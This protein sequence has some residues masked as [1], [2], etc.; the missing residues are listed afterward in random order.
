MKKLLTII[1]ALTTAFLMT[2]AV[3]A[4][5]NGVSEVEVSLDADSVSVNFDGGIEALTLENG[6]V[7]APTDSN[8]PLFA[9]KLPENV[10]IGDTVVVH[11]KG[12]ADDDF[13]VWLLANTTTDEKGNEATFSNQWQ[14]SQNGF[15]APGEFEKYI[16]L[17][18]EDYDAQGGTEADR[19]AFKGPSYGVNLSNLKLTYVGIIKGSIADVEGTAAEEA[20]P[21]ADA[22]KAA[23][24]AANAANGD[25]AALNAA[26]SDAEA[27]VASL[28]E[29]ATLGFPSVND[30][31][32]EAQDVVKTINGIIN[33][34]AESEAVESIS[35][36]VAAVSDALA[37]AQSAGD[38]IDAIK[39]ALESAKTSAANIS[40]VAEANDFT[41][42][43]TA[44]REAEDTVSEIEN[45]LTAAEDAKKAA[46]EAEAKAA[47][48]AAAKKKQTTTIV[49]IVVV[50]VVVLAIVAAVVVSAL[51]KK[52]K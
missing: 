23:L 46:E 32:K 5:D 33:S 4:A 30:M 40:A 11:I 10:A 31:L 39:A 47:E 21:F 34:A 20:K 38:D 37:S 41:A 7:T 1:L 52:K 9:V 42:V 12:S 16:E 43:K 14:A 51:K 15:N 25:E 36:D 2:L 17:T 19:V 35:A 50:V 27:A 24:D 8:V 6:T 48:E 44:A 49:I 45:L 29:K 26:L 18:A 3:S 13:R 22:A 28:E